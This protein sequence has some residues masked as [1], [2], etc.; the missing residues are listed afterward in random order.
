MNSSLQLAPEKVVIDRLRQMALEKMPVADLINF[1][2]HVYSLSKSGYPDDGHVLIMA[3]L[4]KAFD[5]GLHTLLPLREIIQGNIMDDPF[6]KALQ[7]VI[8]YSALLDSTFPGRQR[9]D[10][11]QFKRWFPNYSNASMTS[12]FESDPI[13]E[14]TNGE[15]PHGVE[16]LHRFQEVDQDNVLLKSQLKIYVW[17]VDH[18]PSCSVNSGIA[19]VSQMIER[20]LSYEPNSE[21][22]VEKSLGIV[23]QGPCYMVDLYIAVGG[24]IVSQVATGC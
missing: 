6:L 17:K 12:L 8:Y 5:I 18:V 13:S 24:R 21:N 16:S 15:G 2:R 10:W 9:W 11:K 3:T 14:M 19:R 1:L 22:L 23:D 7:L 20:L 4:C